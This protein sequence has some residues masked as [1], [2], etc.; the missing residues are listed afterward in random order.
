VPADENFKIVFVEATVPTETVLLAQTNEVDPSHVAKLGRRSEGSRTARFGGG[1]CAHWLFSMELLKKKYF[2]C[3][4]KK[5]I[6]PLSNTF[7]HAV[8]FLNCT[9]EPALWQPLP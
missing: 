8:R 7:Q 2:A 6:S 3:A 1:A 4:T 9:H 5:V